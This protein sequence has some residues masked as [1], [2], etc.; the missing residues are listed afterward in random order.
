MVSNSFFDK[1]SR[2]IEQSQKPVLLW[3]YQ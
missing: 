3:V 2:I 1:L